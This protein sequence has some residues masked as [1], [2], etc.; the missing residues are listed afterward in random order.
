M[1]S[2]HALTQALQIKGDL[3]HLSHQ[4]NNMNN[5]D[6]VQEVPQNRWYNPDNGIFHRLPYTCIAKHSD[7]EYKKFR[8]PTDPGIK[9]TFDGDARIREWIGALSVEEIAE[10][11]DRLVDGLA[12]DPA[13]GHGF[14]FTAWQRMS[15]LYYATQPTDMTSCVHIDTETIHALIQYRDHETHRRSAPIQA[16]FSIFK[17]GM[18]KFG[19]VDFATASGKSAWACLVAELAV[20]PEHYPKLLLDYRNERVCLPFEG[21]TTLL[22]ARMIILAT[23]PSTF[24]HFVGTAAKLIAKLQTLRPSTNYHLWTKIGQAFNVG[25]AAELPANAIVFWVIPIKH[26]MKVLRTHPHVAVAVVVVDEFTVDAPTR[27][28]RMAT[29]EIG[30]TFILNATPQALQ[31]ASKGSSQNWIRKLFGGNTLNCPGDIAEYLACRDFTNAQIA[32]EQLCIMDLITMNMFRQLLRND[33]ARLMP[34]SL[35]VHVVRSRTCNIAAHL[36]R[37]DTDF[38]PA[39]FSN[40]LVKLILPFRPTQESLNTFRATLQEF[41][42]S[43]QELESALMALETQDPARSDEHVISRI[44]HRLREFQNTCCPICM[45]D[46]SSSQGGNNSEGAS[47][48]HAMRFYACC[49]FCVCTGCF[50]HW[51]RRPNSRC[52]QCRSVVPNSYQRAEVLLADEQDLEEREEMNRI[53][54]IDAHSNVENLRSANAAPLIQGSGHISGHPEPPL[55]TGLKACTGHLW[56]T[57]ENLMRVLVLLHRLEYRRI[58]ILIQSTMCLGSAVTVSE[59]RIRNASHKA[60]FPMCHIVADKDLGGKGSGFAKIKTVFDDVAADPMILAFFDN[61]RGAGVSIGTD[62]AHADAIVTIGNISHY[63]LTQ[64]LGRGMRPLPGRDPTKPMVM[65]KITISA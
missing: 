2:S 25:V 6:H 31:D 62:L 53:A 63:K 1:P 18:R 37:H 61:A 50:E 30:K 56:K 27:S 5:I 51:N 60:G 58:L 23:A 11:L 65:V 7:D 15:G 46:L 4:E 41:V 19:I 29:S 8:E 33:L 54:R 57:D 13:H 34:P 9:H 40:V 32:A 22:V 12:D 55:Y 49:G 43:T 47:P 64:T 24:D 20:S 59:T 38:V 48:Q 17:G 39:N 44:I 52:P 28:K 42:A 3:V 26:L 14:T 36:A 16:K 45:E 35:D 10:M 21:D